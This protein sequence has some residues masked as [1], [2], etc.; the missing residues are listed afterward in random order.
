MRD[1]EV[2]EVLARCFA[3]I[4]AAEWEAITAPAHWDEF[5]DV[6]RR[7]LQHAYSDPDACAP[8]TRL[9]RDD[10]IEHFLTD[11]EVRALYAPPSAAQMA[12]FAARHFT[13]GLPASAMPVE[14]LYVEW[15]S[16]D[17]K[18]PFGRLE[19]FYA[20]DAALYMRDLMNLLDLDQACSL[21]PYP[22]HLSVELDMAAFLLER[23]DAKT[24]WRYVEERFEWLS[25]YRARLIEVGN[26]TFHLALIDLVLGIRA[27]QCAISDEA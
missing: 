5:V 18:G 1:S 12:S 16:D 23:S 6:A 2:F 20:S 13:G 27:R 4:D 7:L 21:S 11:E 22:D 25:S 26:A 15:T 19:G 9:R 17:E 8:A 3:H 24:A 10:P 14:S